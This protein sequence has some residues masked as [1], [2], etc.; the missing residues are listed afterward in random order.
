MAT[1]C[2]V[3]RFH[4]KGERTLS[5][6]PICVG[7]TRAFHNSDAVAQPANNFEVEKAFD[8]KR[9]CLGHRLSKYKMTR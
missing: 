8:F 7:G 1:S 5:V 4:S 3:M 9:V 2:L 6:S